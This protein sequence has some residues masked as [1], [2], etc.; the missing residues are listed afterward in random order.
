MKCAASASLSIEKYAAPTLAASIAACQRGHDAARHFWP[1]AAYQ[2]YSLQL[3]VAFKYHLMK[4][5]RS[6]IN[7]WRCLR[8][9]D[10]ASLIS[11]SLLTVSI[12]TLYT[13]IIRYF[14]K[15]RLPRTGFPWYYQAAQFRH[16]FG[17]ISPTYFL[18]ERMILIFDQ[19]VKFHSTVYYGC[20]NFMREW[21]SPGPP[22]FLSPR[23]VASSWHFNGVFDERPRNSKKLIWF[24]KRQLFSPIN[25]Q[26]LL[27]W[28]SDIYAPDRASEASNDFTAGDKWAISPVP[29]INIL[30]V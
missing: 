16:V 13:F 29:N 7:I 30:T 25:R 5:I 26:S 18:R 10:M 3:W 27:I 20:R 9:G 28:L 22:A 21:I 2:W 19:R 4:I 6:E 1:R 8:L 12:M 23:R 15:S 24:R 14:R 17:W 11:A